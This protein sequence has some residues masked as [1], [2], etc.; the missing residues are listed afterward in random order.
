[1]VGR[2]KSAAPC[3]RGILIASAVALCLLLWQGWRLGAASALWL[4]PQQRGWLA[5]VRKD[6]ESALALF[7]DPLRIGAAAERMGRYAQAA[8]AY[9]RVDSAPAHFNRG[10]ALLRSREYAQAIVAYE[11][12]LAMAPQWIEAQE[13]LALARHISAYLA[14]QREASDAGEERQPTPEDTRYGRQ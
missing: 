4:T 6:Y 3:L 12:A 2:W 10:N 8:Q 14:Q 11:Q 1:M 9:G 5:F 13:N 7:E